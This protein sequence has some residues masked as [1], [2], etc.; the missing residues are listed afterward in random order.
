MIFLRDHFEPY[1]TFECGQCFR[2]WQVDRF[3]YRGIVEGA[4]V[5]VRPSN[6]GYEAHVVAGQMTDE[7]LNHYFDQAVD[8]NRIKKTLSAKDRWLKEAVVYG[9]GIRLLNQDP[10]ETLVTFIISS[11]NNIPKIK[12]AVE[13]LAELC[14][15]YIGHVD[16]KDRYAFPGPSALAKQDLASLKVKGMGYRNKAV[17]ETVR[18]I[19]DLRLNLNA[20]YGLDYLK[21]KDWLKGFY[22]VGDKVA[23]C[24]L[25]FAYGH[26]DAFPLDTWVKRMLRDLYDIPDTPSAYVAFSSAYFNR[27][28]GYAQQYLFHYIRHLKMRNKE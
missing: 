3:I 13:A 11:N 18:M 21:A 7:R 9:K 10:F 4:I 24:V 25:L 26:K 27:F 14:G 5:E 15:E 12:M 20:P 16:G 6:L 22:G 19:C 23:D 1:D 8:Y 17:F 28:G 2:W